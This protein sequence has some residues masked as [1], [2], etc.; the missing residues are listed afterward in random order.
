MRLATFEIDGHQHIGIADDDGRLVEVTDIVGSD[1]S[2]LIRQ[3]DHMMPQLSGAESGM[4]FPIY[5]EDDVRWLP[6]LPAPGK[7]C[8]IAMSISPDDSHVINAPDHPT[9]TLKPSS[10]LV[11]HR[12]SV[13]VRSYYGS[14]HPRPGLAVIIGKVARDVD[15]ADAHEHIFGFTMFSDITSSGMR[16]ED[17]VERSA[18]W[19]GRCD[20]SDTFGCMGPWLVTS[21]EVD[22][23]DDLDVFFSVGGEIVAESSTCNYPYKIPEIISF[24]SQFQTLEPGDVISCGAAIEQADLQKDGGPVELCIAGLGVLSNPVVVEEQEIGAWR[25]PNE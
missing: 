22:D 19:D 11:G 21:D 6:P 3:A 24:I 15:A 12:E 5:A 2:R 7:I 14:V 25:L 16:S 1:M 13:R 18:S 4:Q 23:P 9:F 20:G 8:A 17:P 10:C